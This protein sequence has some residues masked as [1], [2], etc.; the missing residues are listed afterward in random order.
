MIGCVDGWNSRG[1]AW[2]AGRGFDTSPEPGALVR[3]QSGTLSNTKRLQKPKWPK[4]EEVE[5]PLFGPF[6][7]LDLVSRRHFLDTKTSPLCQ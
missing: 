5:N 6:F 2:E 3:F 1:S 4:R 7:Y